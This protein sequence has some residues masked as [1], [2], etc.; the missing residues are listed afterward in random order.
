MILALV[1]F[2]TGIAFAIG[3]AWIAVSYADRLLNEPSDDFSD[4]DIRLSGLASHART[5]DI[6]RQQRVG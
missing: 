1:G 6:E 2:I 5:S 4:G 3:C